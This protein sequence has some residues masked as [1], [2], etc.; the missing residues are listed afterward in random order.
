MSEASGVVQVRAVEPSAEEVTKTGTP[1]AAALVV[2]DDE[3]D[4]DGESGPYNRRS[5]GLISW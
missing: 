5:G 2:S 1:A 3:D 4:T